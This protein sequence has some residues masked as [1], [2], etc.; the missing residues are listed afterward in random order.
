MSEAE[1]KIGP[2]PA[3][4]L[5]T[6]LLHYASFNFIQGFESTTEIREVIPSRDMFFVSRVHILIT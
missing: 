5:I 4:M 6:N 3:F 1:P 2:R